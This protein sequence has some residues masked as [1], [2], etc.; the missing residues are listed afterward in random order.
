MTND[1][2]FARFLLYID[3]VLPKLPDGIVAEFS[4]G[5]DLNESV[6]FV[7]EFCQ[8]ASNRE[9]KLK[10]ENNESVAKR[11]ELDANGIVADA[12]IIGNGVFALEPKQTIPI[13]QG[14]FY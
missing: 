8:G 3:D 1:N 12:A 11:S 13:G 6:I 10:L 9:V 7:R 2:Q 4:R 5:D 14:Q